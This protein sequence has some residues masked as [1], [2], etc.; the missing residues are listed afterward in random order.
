MQ[1]KLVVQG[2]SKAGLEIPVTGPRFLIG[3]EEGCQ[4]RPKSDL[5]SRKHCEIVFDDGHVVV[6]DLNSRNGV[7]VNGEKIDREHV[8]EPGDALRV[9]A[10]E[11]TVDINHTLG[12]GKRAP[13]KNVE[14]AAARL[15]EAKPDQGNIANWLS[16][17]D[18][19]ERV[20]RI[21]APEGRQYKLADAADP[22]MKSD[23]TGE[24]AIPSGDETVIE[25]P[26]AAGKKDSG[27]FGMFGGGKKKSKEKGKLPERAEE[28]TKNTR[29][30]ASDAL[31]RFFN[32]R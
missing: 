4:L 18:E 8:V 20:R 12:A 25:S 7:Y 6:R 24:M 30:A 23:V 14:E 5:I 29:D 31:K 17:A 1:V 27:F 3:R 9:G 16:E 15:A 19:R 32:Q 22:T 13:V 11:F 28:D 2:G 21:A 26:G 10:L